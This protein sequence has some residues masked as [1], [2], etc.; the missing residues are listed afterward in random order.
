MYERTLSQISP[1]A[2]AVS[3]PLYSHYD[4][5]TTRFTEVVED[6]E[7]GLPVFTKTQDTTPIVESAKALASNFSGTPAHGITHVARIPNVVWQRLVMTG[8][9]RDERAL[10]NWLNDP[11]NRV[12]RCDDGRRL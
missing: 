8:V 1:K 12:F 11:D 7:T 2:T 10:N 3:A 6:S 4:P 5:V 9:A